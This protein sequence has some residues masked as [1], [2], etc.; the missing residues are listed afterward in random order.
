MKLTRNTVLITLVVLVVVLIGIMLYGNSK[1]K[2]EVDELLLSI[3]QEPEGC[4]Q[5]G[6]IQNVQSDNLFDA[7]HY[8]YVLYEAKGKCWVCPDDIQDVYDVLSNKNLPEIA[9]LDNAMKNR[10]GVSILEHLKSFLS[11]SELSKAQ[12][13]IDSAPQ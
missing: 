12:T 11:D 3:Q 6:N 5:L 7:N 8:A 1:K 9:A 10:Y 13:I 2:K 4:I